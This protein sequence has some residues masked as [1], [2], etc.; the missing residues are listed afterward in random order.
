MLHFVSMLWSSHLVKVVN[1]TGIS[2]LHAEPATGTQAHACAMAFV[3][4]LLC[5]AL[6]DATCKIS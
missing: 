6:G 1:L 4:S 5:H 2:K 3:Q